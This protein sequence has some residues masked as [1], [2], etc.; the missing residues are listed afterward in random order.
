[1]ENADDRRVHGT[2]FA[3]EKNVK[4]KLTR[5][6]VDEIL[7]KLHAGTPYSKIMGEYGIS[8]GHVSRINRGTAWV[9][10]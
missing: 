7:T 4:A 9:A 2:N 1:M 5:K 8:K 6:I 3:G 10:V